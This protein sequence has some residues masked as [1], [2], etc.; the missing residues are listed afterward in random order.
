MAKMGDDAEFD[1]YLCVVPQTHIFAVDDHA[2]T[3]P[4]V[5]ELLFGE[6]FWGREELFDDGTG[7][8]WI[9]GFSAH[10]RYRG[11]IHQSAVHKQALT[12]SNRQH[13]SAV[14]TTKHTPLFTA[15]D[16][17]SHVAKQ[18]SLGSLIPTSWLAGPLHQQDKFLEIVLPQDARSLWLHRRHI[19]QSPIV[20]TDIAASAMTLCGVPYIWGGRSDLG[21]DCSALVQFA[22]AKSGR[23][24]PRDSDQQAETVGE[25]VAN[26]TVPIDT[27]PDGLHC[28]D[29]VFFPGHVGIMVDDVN[30]V[31][32]NATHMAVTVNP[33]REVIKTIDAEHGARITSVRR[34]ST[35]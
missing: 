28:G 23:M 20:E 10:D 35:A 4:K 9:I 8:G 2:G 5:S 11:R 18:L 25:Q 21:L 12:T 1:Y 24:T 32:A 15:P 16:L 22:F 26:I 27:V 34:L 30:L 29:L 14:V 7:S 19:E 31:H 13:V 33:L 17:K 3:S 6:G